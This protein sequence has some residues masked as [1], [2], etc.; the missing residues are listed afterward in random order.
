MDGLLLALELGWPTLNVFS[1]N[2]PPGYGTPS[3]CRELP[4][5]ITQYIAFARAH[6]FRFVP[7]YQD[8]MKRVVPVGFTDCDPGWW[9][10]AP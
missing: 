4:N 9:E 1:G 10:Q 2:E 8:L 7:N 6:N 5:R 3:T